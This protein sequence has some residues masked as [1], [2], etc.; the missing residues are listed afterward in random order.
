ML[1]YALAMEHVPGMRILYEPLPQ[2]NR[3]R[4]WQAALGDE[5]LKDIEAG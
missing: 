4:T 3:Q 2:S 5:L 1:S